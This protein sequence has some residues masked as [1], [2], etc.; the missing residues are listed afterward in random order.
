[1][2]KPSVVLPVVVLIMSLLCGGC[3]Q[4]NGGGKVKT[5][6]MVVFVAQEGGF[7]GIVAKDGSRYNPISLPEQFQKDSL[8]VRFEGKIRT[9]MATIHM[10][11][12]LIE[13]TSIKPVGQ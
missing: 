11:G 13:I 4:G 6:G 8:S 1:M 10:W 12:K 3:N 9:D 2:P 7:Y 5:E